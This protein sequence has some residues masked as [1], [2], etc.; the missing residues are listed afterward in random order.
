[1][2]LQLI[3]PPALEPISILEARA[4][5]RIDTAE[6]DGLLAGYIIAARRHCET[7]LERVLIT[8]TWDATYD[9][10]WPREYEAHGYWLRYVIRPPIQ[11]L[12][13]VTSITY[14]D[15]AGVSQ[16]LG[17]SLYVVHAG[18]DRVGY[19]DL[20]HGQSWPEV[21]C[22]TDAITMR[23]VAGYGSIPSDVDEPIRQA[24]LLLIGHWYENR[25]ASI[26]GTSAVELPL[27]VRAL[28]A[29]HVNI[30]L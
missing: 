15:T 4:H 7:H 3:T 30:Q 19:V 16:T 14:V 25:E 21:R 2:G 18:K 20:A 24:M 5:C 27:G 13:S 29:P 22:Q 17:T 8:Q 26:V 12:Q 23:F 1:M 11:P 6:D 28:L 10:G 9:W